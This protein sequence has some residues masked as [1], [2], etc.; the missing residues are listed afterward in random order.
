MV[1]EFTG[2]SALTGYT[3]NIN[4]I[5][6]DLAQV[7]QIKIGYSLTGN[8]IESN[9]SIIFLLGTGTIT[10]YNPYT[11][12]YI[13]VGSGGGGGGGQLSGGGAGGGGGGGFGT[14]II[15]LN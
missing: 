15:Y 9:N 13:L 11:V 8:Y 14:C 4:G 1:P 3:T 6:Y 10:F 7:F 12:N 2:T 5:V